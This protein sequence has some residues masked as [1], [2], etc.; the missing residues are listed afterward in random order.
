MGGV[1]VRV[2]R[3]VTALNGVVRAAGRQRWL[4]VWLPTDAESSNLSR[5][6][7]DLP[8]TVDDCFA[9]ADPTLTCRVGRFIVPDT[10]LTMITVVERVDAVA[11]EQVTGWYCR[12]S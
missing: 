9:G 5:V 7:G 2:D 4:W 3:E 8:S 6:T 12:C 10:G 11:T 1:T